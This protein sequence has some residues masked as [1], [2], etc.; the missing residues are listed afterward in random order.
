ME[1]SGQT[2]TNSKNRSD[3]G[4]AF[5]LIAGLS[6]HDGTKD[7]PASLLVSLSGDH[8]THVQQY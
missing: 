4:C 6:W 3:T 8:D 1:L 5:V 7:V 2:A